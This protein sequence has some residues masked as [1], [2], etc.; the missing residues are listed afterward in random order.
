MTRPIAPLFVPGYSA[1]RLEKA[2]ELGLRAIL[3]DLEDSVPL[4]EKALARDGAAA[5]VEAAPGVCSVRINPLSVEGGRTT[6]CGEADIV[7]VM[8]PG[9][10][11][12][13]YP[14]IETAEEL[15]RLDA[16]I[17]AAEID[18][19]LALNSV[20]L[21]V[22]IETALGLVNANAI[23]RAGLK[24]PLSFGFGMADFTADL[25]IEWTRDEDETLAAR[26][27]LPI[28]SRAA[29][30]EKPGDSVFVNVEDD[31]GLRASA[32]RG[33]RLGYGGKAAIHPRQ[34]PIIHDA[35]KPTEA[36][37]GQAQK[38]LDAAAQFAAEGQGAFLLEGRMVD[39]PIV[40][41]ARDLLDFN[42]TFS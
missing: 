30:L 26:S 36:E 20:R 17:G 19:G 42:A 23:A 11:G 12:L 27:M 24:R 22:T 7:S 41:R 1:R 33:K 2:L 21:S 35:Y 18:A 6:A 25:G 38:I 3:V 9:L 29:G 15:V 5:V 39:E 16:V 31:E 34:I 8:G 40:A 13:V 4:G 28:I 10:A 32:L 14:K 37:V